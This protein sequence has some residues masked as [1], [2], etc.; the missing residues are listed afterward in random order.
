MADLESDSEFMYHDSC[1]DCGSSDALAVYS[2]EHTYC[3]SCHKLTLPNESHSSFDYVPL[4][5]GH[6]VQLRKR[7]LSEKT[8]KKYKI[9]KTETD[10][11][12]IISIAL[13]RCLARRSRQ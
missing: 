2:D 11:D 4:L 5:R 8:C 13:E 12:S 3:F 7:G 10:S 6:P 9:T 1:P